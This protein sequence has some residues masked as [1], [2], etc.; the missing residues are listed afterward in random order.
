MGNNAVHG[1]LKRKRKKSSELSKD[2]SSERPRETKRDAAT[3]SVMDFYDK[4]DEMAG[5]LMNSDDGLD[6]EESEIEEYYKGE[7][8]RK[9]DSSKISLSDLISSL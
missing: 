6:Q 1:S 8:K 7:R 5:D 3:V 2:S 9:F 4:R